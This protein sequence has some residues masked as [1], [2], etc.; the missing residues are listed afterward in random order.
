MIPLSAL[1][2]SVTA[3]AHSKVCCVGDV[4]LDHFHYGTVE[5]ISP[6]APVPVVRVEREVSM[7]GAAGNVVRNLIAMGAEA[8]FVTVVGDD[9]AGTEVGKLF[10]DLKLEDV[11]IVDTDRRT[12]TKTRY[13]AG[14]QQIL[15]ADH[16]SPFSLVPEIEQ[17]VIE[18]ATAVLGQCDA[19][20][21]SDYSKGV[22]T[23][24]ALAELI[25]LAGESGKP[26]IV[27]PK[28]RHYARY[29]GADLITPNRRE[30]T[31][32]TS[33]PVDL[34]DDIVAAAR[35]LIDRYDFGSVLAT[36]SQDGMTLVTKA[37]EV[38]HL[39]ADARE[40][41]DVTGA[42]DTV[43]AVMAAALGAGVGVRGAAEVANVAA[44]IVVG[45]LGTA[46][47][48]AEEVI[49][50][51]HHQD[52]SNAEAKVLSRAQALERIDKWRHQNV[53]I[54]FTNGVFDLLHPGHVSLLAQAHDACDRLIVGLNSDA[55]V[56][57]VKGDDRP[58]QAEAARAT[59]LASLVS[60][61][62]VVIFAEDTPLK[63]LEAI[64]PDVL[65]KGA[66]YSIGDV[67]GA[68]VVK[69][70]GGTIL[71]ADLAEGHSTTATIGRINRATA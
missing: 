17:Q 23:D 63:L 4:M 8:R 60:V 61:D 19:L 54:G 65:V 40:V 15:R 29:R 2:T 41:Y 16:E 12:S 25:F 34:A 27:D 28:G 70:Y 7:V 14:V 31:D 3:L 38:H 45:K 6:E 1:I 53:K 5:R 59:V 64:R 24:K 46:V 10:E 30:L 57:R 11:P 33:M 62:M 36:R 47:A 66:D 55:S 68:E 48:D 37:G 43:A 49:W 69:G 9:S 58:I 52:I 71:L 13:I 32:A 20:V 67:I 44:G 22:L 35:H 39:P 50:A 18:R 26:V 21:L 51:I 56:K 42:G